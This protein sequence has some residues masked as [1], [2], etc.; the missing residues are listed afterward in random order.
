[1]MNNELSNQCS[2]EVTN[3]DILQA[4]KKIPG[5]L[6]ITP[7]DFME[8]YQVAYAHAVERLRSSI[9]AEHIMTKI[10]ITIKEN[11]SLADTAKIMASHNFSG[12]PVLNDENQV[13]GIISENDFLKQMNPSGQPSFMHVV[14]QC[15]E[16]KGYVALNL[17]T[18]SAKDI[19][20][21]P[22][23]SVKTTTPIRE[24]ANILDTHHI[25]RVPVLDENMN[26]TGIIARSDLV[27][28]VCWPTTK[29]DKGNETS[30]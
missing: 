4:M 8:I 16:V 11:A 1:M 29:G 26:L 7:A 20:S 21:S 25:N 10:V 12:I 17:K 28:S 6:D 15:L 30:Q 23:I 22:P 3:E 5:Y 18:L 19:M 2:P 24:V 27:Q 9:K 14:L 13:S